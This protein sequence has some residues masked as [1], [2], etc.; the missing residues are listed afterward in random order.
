MKTGRSLN[1]LAIELDRQAKSKRDF[2]ADTRALRVVPNQSGAIVLEGIGSDGF[3]LRPT[4]HEQMAATLA[5]P[6]PYYDRMMS[7]APDLLAKNINHWLTATPSRKMVRTLDGG[8]RGILSERYRPLDNIDLIEAVLPRLRQL[9][10]EV[11]SGEVTDRL[12]YV[13]AVTPRIQGVVDKIKSGVH[14]R[15]DDVIQAG[16]AISNSEIGFGALKLEEMTYRLVCINGAIHAVAVRK[17]H[18]GRGSSYS[19]ADLIEQSQEF[20]RD[21]T[22]QADDKAFFLKVRDSVSAVLTQERL[23]K[24]LLQMRGATERVIENDPVAV[25]EATAK[26]FNFGQNEQSSILKHLI[27]GGDLSAFGLGNAITRASQDQESYEVATSMEMA[28]ASVFELPQREWQSL[29]GK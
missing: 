23:D 8:V 17:T 28:G 19:D 20:F 27:Q 29:A 5:I 26:R 24:H 10:A 12:F 1:E 18:A 11:V 25:V 9:D 13:K 3:A 7:D 14:Q 21:E 16:I 15:T 4:A 22:R 6:K 2:L